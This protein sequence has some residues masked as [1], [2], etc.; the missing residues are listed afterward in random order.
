M[1]IFLLV[2]FMVIAILGLIYRVDT[3]VFVGLSLIP[4]QVIR[5]KLGEKINLAVIMITTVGGSIFFI[6][7][8]KWLLLLLF[9]GIESYN[10]W[11]HLRSLTEIE[12]QAAEESANNNRI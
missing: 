10:Y 11:G 3:G 8:Q 2:F 4:W 1:N 9:L 5:L 7:L 12:E 6:Y